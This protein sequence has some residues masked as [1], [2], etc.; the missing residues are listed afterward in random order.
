[1]NLQFITYSLSFVWKFWDYGVLTY[2]LFPVSLWIKHYLLIFMPKSH[3][4]Y[5]P[6]YFFLTAFVKVQ[7]LLAHRT[8]GNHLY[9][10]INLIVRDIPF[11]IVRIVFDLCQCVIITLIANNGLACPTFR[12][13][14]LGWN[15]VTGFAQNCIDIFTSF[16]YILGFD[17]ACILIS[18]AYALWQLFLANAKM[19]LLHL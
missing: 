3:L 5:Y 13:I 15:H 18:D 14:K 9:I 2:C 10:I 8:L 17:H 1:M 12:N 16:C 11:L 4:F 6:F 7:C 19:L